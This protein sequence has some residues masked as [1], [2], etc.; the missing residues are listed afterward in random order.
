M[1]NTKYIEVQALIVHR[2]Q[3]YLI[4]WKGECSKVM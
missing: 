1:N 4:F 2:A 3:N